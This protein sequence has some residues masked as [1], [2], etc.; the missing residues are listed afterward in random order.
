VNSSSRLVRKCEGDYA[1]L[2]AVNPNDDPDALF[3]P[4]GGVRPKA[5]PA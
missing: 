1:R 5:G 4:L 2:R 3:G